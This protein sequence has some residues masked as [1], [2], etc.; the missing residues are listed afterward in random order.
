M[1]IVECRAFVAFVFSTSS[2]ANCAVGFSYIPN[3]YDSA[4]AESKEARVARIADKRNRRPRKRYHWHTPA[5]LY[6]A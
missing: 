1:P 3:A 6:A 4:A 2:R 5:E